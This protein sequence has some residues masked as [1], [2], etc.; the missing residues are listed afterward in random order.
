[1]PC[2]CPLATVFVQVFRILF[3]VTVNSTVKEFFSGGYFSCTNVNVLRI[4]KL[5]KDAIVAPYLFIMLKRTT[6]VWV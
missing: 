4:I 5:F 3:V 6:V 2:V 1:M